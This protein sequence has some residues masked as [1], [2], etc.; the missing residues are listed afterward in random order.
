MTIEIKITTQP[1]EQA[2]IPTDC[3]N[4]K[5]IFTHANACHSTLCSWLVKDSLINLL[6]AKN[7]KL[8]YENAEITRFPK[9]E[10]RLPSDN[11]SSDGLSV[12]IAV[13]L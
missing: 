12:W 5:W 6:R 10:N 13:H 7:I 8:F 4:I 9:N 1:V 2:S 3:I 11:I